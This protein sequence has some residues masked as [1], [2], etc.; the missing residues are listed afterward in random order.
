MFKFNTSVRKDAA[1][2]EKGCAQTVSKDRSQTLATSVMTQSEPSQPARSNPCLSSLRGPGQ[3]VPAPVP[4]RRRDSKPISASL[5]SRNKI[6]S[7]LRM[8]LGSKFIATARLWHLPCLLTLPRYFLLVSTVVT[9]DAGPQKGTGSRGRNRQC[10]SPPGLRLCSRLLP[11]DPPATLRGCCYCCS[12]KSFPSAGLCSHP[13][14]FS[15]ENILM[16]VLGIS[17]LTECSLTVTGIQSCL[18]ISSKK[19]TFSSHLQHQKEERTPLVN[20]SVQ[21]FAERRVHENKGGR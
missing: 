20:R 11:Q 16:T 6:T 2:E 8:V 3:P 13:G 4:K 7:L 5:P 10:C 19:N 17:G 15:G 1:R 21:T 18:E 12:K 9:K 14:L